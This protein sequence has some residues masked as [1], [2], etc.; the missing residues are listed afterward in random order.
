MALPR[1]C[2]PSCH[3]NSPRPSDAGRPSGTA[4]PPVDRKD[5][6]SR[7]VTMRLVLSTEPSV[8]LQ[9]GPRAV[10]GGQPPD[11]A[12]PP[13]RVAGHRRAGLLPVQ[14]LALL[15]CQSGGS[16][17][18]P[19]APTRQRGLSH[20]Q[21]APSPPQWRGGLCT[22]SCARHWQNR[23][24]FP[25]APRNR[26][27]GGAPPQERPEL[28]P[29]R[30]PRLLM[31]RSPSLPSGAPSYGRRKRSHRAGPDRR[32]P[33]DSCSA[34]RAPRLNSGSAEPQRPLPLRRQ[35]Q[36]S[37]RPRQAHNPRAGFEM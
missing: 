3:V 28:P 1:R 33:L 15:P 20:G 18:I 32:A 21:D 27:P 7:A 31:R 35:A 30:R 24:E 19:T 13:G 25:G 10:S 5:A 8:R 34:C 17:S 6:S 9:E 16:G 4:P 26:L 22:V 36:F 2:H 23:G 29:E 12:C 14:P 11:F 37:N